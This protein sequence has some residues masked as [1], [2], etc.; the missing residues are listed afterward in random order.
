MLFW[1]SFRS[2]RAM[3]VIT[4]KM[5]TYTE[6]TFNINVS[7]Q[8][9]LGTDIPIPISLNLQKYSIGM[10]YNL[11]GF[12]AMKNVAWAEMFH[13]KKQLPKHKFINGQKGYWNVSHWLKSNEYKPETVEIWQTFAFNN[14]MSNDFS[15]VK[16]WKS[17]MST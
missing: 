8:I 1:N 6:Y 9:L 11:R 16:K 12:G 14:I 10:Q 7:K 2:Y 17:H 13:L 15:Q 5:S 3:T 4:I